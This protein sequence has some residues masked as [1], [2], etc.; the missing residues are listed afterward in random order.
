MS[1]EVAIDPQQLRLFVAKAIY[2]SLFN[3][4]ITQTPAGLG[5]NVTRSPVLLAPQGRE[6]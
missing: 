1:A 3:I 2:T 4:R 5:R 6:S